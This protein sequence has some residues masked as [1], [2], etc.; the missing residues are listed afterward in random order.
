MNRRSASTM[1][2]NP[3]TEPADPRRFRHLVHHP[4]QSSLFCLYTPRRGT[5]GANFDRICH[6]PAL[7]SQP[8]L[9]SQMVHQTNNKGNTRFNRHPTHLHHARA[10]SLAPPNPF[11]HARSS[12]MLAT[13]TRE[14]AT[15]A[16]QKHTG[17]LT[18]SVHVR[19]V[20][21]HL[22]LCYS[23]RAS[24]NTDSED[25][26][27]DVL[28]AIHLTPACSKTSHPCSTPRG[29]YIHTSQA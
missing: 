4:S 28:G 5:A 25:V 3:T 2:S 24:I 22:E 27:E 8:G 12:S 26:C 9:L 11:M 7:T 15:A 19:G 1:S 29:I 16:N 21:I 10:R 6:C 20:H 13:I 18:S 17:L 23:M 14:S